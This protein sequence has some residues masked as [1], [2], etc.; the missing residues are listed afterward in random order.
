MFIYLE[1]GVRRADY[2]IDA[3]THDHHVDDSDLSRRHGEPPHC[4]G[5]MNNCGGESAMRPAAS[6]GGKPVEPGL[7]SAEHEL[8][9]QPR[10]MPTPGLVKQGIL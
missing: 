8:I 9:L 5:V 3:E 1:T 10:L 4:L 2:K 7:G 6:G